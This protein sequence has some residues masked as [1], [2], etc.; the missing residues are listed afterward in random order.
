[1]TTSGR[2][3]SHLDLGFER[4]MQ[5]VSH[6]AL[7]EETL[8][9]LVRPADGAPNQS[10]RAPVPQPCLPAAADHFF[11]L[12]RLAPDAPIAVPAGFAV[13]IVLDGEGRAAGADTVTLSRGETWVVPAAFG[14]WALD[15]DVTLLLARPG[16]GWPGD[17]GGTP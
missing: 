4:A 2:E 16:A 9:T 8:A 3:D 15:G 14:D 13:A 10:R 11:R 12:H 5:A 1:V 17:L 7:G 6:H